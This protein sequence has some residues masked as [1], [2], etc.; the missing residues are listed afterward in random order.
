MTA[1]DP[2][3]FDQS[4][5]LGEITKLGRIIEISYLDYVKI[6]AVWGVAFII[7]TYWMEVGDFIESEQNVVDIN[8]VTTRVRHICTC[9]DVYRGNVCHDVWRSRCDQPRNNMAYFYR[10][11]AISSWT[12]RSNY[13]RMGNLF[14]SA[15]QGIIDLEL[16]PAS[17][18]RAS[19]RFLS[20]FYYH[21]KSSRRACQRWQAFDYLAIEASSSNLG[22]K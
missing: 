8:Y 1:P 3:A 20:L 14:T 5:S 17:L 18:D 4:H 9:L 7:H 21:V 22:G 6:K 12:T 16:Y 11:L 2:F 13:R 10:Y 15:L 19:R